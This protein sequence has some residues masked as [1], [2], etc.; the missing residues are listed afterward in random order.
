[1][2][3][4][5]QDT[6]TLTGTIKTLRMDRGFGFITPDGA[7]G[8]GSDV[9]FHRSAVVGTDFDDLQ[10]GERVSFHEQMNP[11]SGRTEAVDVRPISG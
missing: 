11:R 5:N 8:R 10:E 2:V 6:T 3:G 4:T 9:F 7:R 1:M